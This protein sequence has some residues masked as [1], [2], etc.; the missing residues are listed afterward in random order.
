M[1]EIYIMKIQ[2]LL[3]TLLLSLLTINGYSANGENE[4]SQTKK[5]T[6]AKYDYTLFKMFSLNATKTVDSDSTTTKLSAQ[7]IDRKKD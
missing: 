5:T 4:P 3:F 1:S 7:P 6:K 2:T